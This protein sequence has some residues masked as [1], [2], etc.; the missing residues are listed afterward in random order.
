MLVGFLH[1]RACATSEDGECLSNLC[2]SSFSRPITL[3]KNLPKHRFSRVLRVGEL[4]L[5]SVS[6]IIQHPT[7]DGRTSFLNRFTFIPQCFVAKAVI[8]TIHQ[9]WQMIYGLSRISFSERSFAVYLLD[10]EVT[11]GSTIGP[12]ELVRQTTPTNSVN[13]FLHHRYHYSEPAKAWS[14]V[15]YII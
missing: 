15:Q 14:L 5:P 2:Y 1:S 3:K 8:E 10:H 13:L 4:A 9:T 12:T 6:Q 11:N 7:A